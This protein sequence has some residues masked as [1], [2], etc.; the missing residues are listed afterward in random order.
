MGRIAA[1]WASMA[2]LLLIL[3]VIFIDATVES[4][5]ETLATS[6]EMEGKDGWVQN[7]RNAIGK[8]YFSRAMNGYI[9]AY[10]DLRKKEEA[11]QQACF[12]SAC[13]ATWAEPEDV[14]KLREATVKSSS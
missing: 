9:K 10:D 7:T 11:L 6:S 14:K 13:D 1:I 3:T 2:A 8:S 12:I 4:R 5:M